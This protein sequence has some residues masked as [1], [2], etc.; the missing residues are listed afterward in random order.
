[1]RA[2][3]ASTCITTHRGTGHF[4]SPLQVALPTRLDP[5]SDLDLRGV[6][7][8][9]FIVLLHNHLSHPQRKDMSL[10]TTSSGTY[11]QSS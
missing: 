8:W 4:P 1:M 3:M 6:L 11:D 2:T 10:A 9:L 7:I 5:L